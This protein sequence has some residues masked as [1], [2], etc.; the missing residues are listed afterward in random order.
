M[1]AWLSFKNNELKL[2][3]TVSKDEY[4]GG[5]T[6]QQLTNASEYLDLVKSRTISIFNHYVRMTQI[7]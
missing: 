2:I 7:Y 5:G 4:S 6:V 3:D 1:R